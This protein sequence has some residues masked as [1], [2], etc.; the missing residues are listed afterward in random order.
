M[1][2]IAEKIPG[3]VRSAVIGTV[4]FAAGFV[5][6]YYVDYRN[7]YVEALN[8]NYAQFDKA[9]ED[10]RETLKIFADISRGVKPKSDNDV[11]ALQMKLLVAVGKVEDLSRRVDGG[12]TFVRTY[13][14]AAVNLRNAAETVNGPLNG[15]VMVDA[16]N[17]FLLAE[18]QV[19][20]SVLQ[21]YNSFLW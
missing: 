19:R 18:N 17:D 21:E 2:A 5:T 3:W 20:D 9:S 12:P 6:N 11:T 8:A 7:N 1:M 16:V 4:A 13:Q 14:D 10:I 15:K